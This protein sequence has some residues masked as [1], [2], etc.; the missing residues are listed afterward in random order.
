MSRSV[1]DLLDENGKVDVSAIRSAQTVNCGG[2]NKITDE[3][4]RRMRRVAAHIDTRSPQVAEGFDVSETTVRRHLGGKCSC[5][6]DVPSLEFE[7]G[8]SK[9]WVLSDENQ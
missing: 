6:H 8:D 3:K 5:S 4:C 9:R 1:S 7:Y 2:K